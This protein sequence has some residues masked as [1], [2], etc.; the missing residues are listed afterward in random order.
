[1]DH[2][3][4]SWKAKEEQSKQNPDCNPPQNVMLGLLSV[5]ASPSRWD[6]HLSFPAA[7]HSPNCVGT[8]SN[9][10]HVQEPLAHHD[11]Q[12][13]EHRSCN[14]LAT[15]ALKRA[16]PQ[17][18]F[19]PMPHLKTE[20]PCRSPQQPLPLFPDY[21][22]LMNSP[23]WGAAPEP[24]PALLAEVWCT[25]LRDHSWGLR[26]PISPQPC[27]D[28]PVG[29]WKEALPAFPLP[30]L[31]LG[32]GKPQESLRRKIARARFLL[33]ASCWIQAGF[34]AIS[35]RFF[36]L[37]YEIGAC[38]IHQGPH[39]LGASNFWFCCSAH[40]LLTRTQFD[41]QSQNWHL[42]TVLL[43]CLTLLKSSLTQIGKRWHP[44]CPSLWMSQ[45]LVW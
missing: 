27:P 20:C 22:F 24:Q 21:F 14:L 8:R 32:R 19:Y 10:A 26:D 6:I 4:S 34:W 43:C 7:S 41:V 35:F 18:L 36:P 33:G 17:N 13:L 15:T 11:K 28:I 44:W 40:K 45:A 23:G 5:A 3:G 25:S 37:S 2:F 29:A 42:V 9:S 16:V 39:Y 30:S 38:I 1:M 31:A 12:A